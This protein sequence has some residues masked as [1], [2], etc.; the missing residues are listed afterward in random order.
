VTRPQ[1]CVRVVGPFE[2]VGVDI[3]GPFPRSNA[4][5]K[6]VILAVDYLTKWTMTRAVPSANADEV[7]RFFLEKIV[8]H[9]GAPR[10]IITDQGKCF[11][12]KTVD[13][14]LQK[15]RIKHNLASVGWP[16]GNALTERVIRTIT[17]MIAMFVSPSQEDWDAI[18]PALTFAYNTSQQQATGK[19]PFFLTRTRTSIPN[20]HSNWGRTPVVEGVRGQR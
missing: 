17:D 19:T 14:A 20:R 5:N 9:H 2:T 16:R 18:L 1:Q 8:Y 10:R 11:V 15:L 13:T 7:V 3:L 4:G 12:A 6:Y